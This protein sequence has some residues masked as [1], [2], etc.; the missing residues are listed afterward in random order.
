MKEKLKENKTEHLIHPWGALY[1]KDSELLILGS[2]PSP[3]S[4]EDNFFYGHK[5]NRFWR[6][7]AQLFGEPAPQSID[8]KKALVKRHHIALWDVIYECDITGA[9]DAS[10]KNARPTEIGELLKSSK[11]RAVFC[12]GAKAY[13]LYLRYQFKATGMQAQKLPSTSPANAACSF[14]ELLRVWSVIKEA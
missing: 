2:F 3:K 7:I 11:I 8:E 1:D 9:S 4:R 14:E 6:L 12:N 13:E 5:Q 10:V